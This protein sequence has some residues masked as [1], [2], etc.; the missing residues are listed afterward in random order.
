MVG[1]GINDAPALTQADVGIAIGTGTDVAIEASDVTLIKDDLRAVA[2]A[3]RLSRRTMTT[4]KTNLFW[5]FFYNIIGIPIAAGV[6]FPFFGAK[7]LLNPMLASAAMAFSSVSV[8][9]NSLRLK[10]FK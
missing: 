4:I 3:M 6:L 7:G 9:T 5:A 10:R 2:T 1:D 8:V